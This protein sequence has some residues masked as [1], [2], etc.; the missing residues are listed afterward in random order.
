MRVSRSRQLYQRLRELDEGFAQVNRALSSM[1]SFRGFHA[2][3]LAR[4]SALA[5]EA[6]AA[7]LSYLLEI[8]AESESRKA[9][10]LFNSRQ[11]RGRRDAGK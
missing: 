7:T 1:G 11:A 9:G 10:R 4:C 8:V 3:E 2:D 6:R 5:E